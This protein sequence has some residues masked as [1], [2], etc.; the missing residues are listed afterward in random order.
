MSDVV[1]VIEYNEGSRDKGKGKM[2]EQDVDIA[3]AIVSRIY[4]ADCPNILTAMKSI[5][6]SFVSRKDED[7]ASESEH[8]FR[9]KFLLYHVGYLT[10]RPPRP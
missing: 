10:Q 1:A 2:A 8:V 6:T 7:E 9:C 3:P 5:I 4:P